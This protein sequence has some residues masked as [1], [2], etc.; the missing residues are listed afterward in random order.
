MVMHSRRS[1]SHDV[2]IF[3]FIII[4]ISHL[5]S[6][7]CFFSYIFHNYNC[8][9]DKRNKK[10][11]LIC[12]FFYTFSL[13]IF[14]FSIVCVLD[15]SRFKFSLAVYI[16]YLI[17]CW[18]YLLLPNFWRFKLKINLIHLALCKSNWPM[19]NDGRYHRNLYEKRCVIPIRNQNRII[20]CKHNGQVNSLVNIYCPWNNNKKR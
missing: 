9:D 6:F 15:R 1:I 8:S 14:V 10:L 13:C 4:F 2:K 11:L 7:G 19:A 3:I 16:L 17:K 12:S 5:L 20:N 18:I